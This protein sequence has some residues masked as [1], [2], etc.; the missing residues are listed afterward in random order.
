MST[1]LISETI[2]VRPPALRITTCVGVF[3]LL[4]LNALVRMSHKAGRRQTKRTRELV[5]QLSDAMTGIKPLMAMERQSRFMQLFGHKL[6]DLRRGLR[7]EVVSKQLMSNLREPILVV[8]LGI[9]FYITVK[10]WALPIS[11]LLVLGLLLERTANTIGKL[12]KQL[13]EVAAFEAAYWSVHNLI[14]ES[15]QEREQITGTIQPTLAKG[16]QVC[17]VSFGFGD[18][19][20][21]RNLSMD[22]HARQVTVIMGASGVG[23]TTLTDL[24]LGLHRP[25]EGQILIDGVPLERIDIRAWRAMVGYVPQE[26]IL[27]HD[28]ILANVTLGD[29]SIS[30]DAVQ[31]ALEA[32]GAWDFVSAMPDGCLSQVGERGMKL[33]GGERQRIAIARAL[34][35]KPDLLILDEVT[36]ALDRETELAICAQIRCLANSVTVVAITHRPAWVNIADRVYELGTDEFSEKPVVE[37]LM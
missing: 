21:L 14:N 2:W 37:Q 18:Q 5:T 22:I 19:P 15:A 36:S 28:S 33:S 7:R 34:V 12:Q 1:P 9:G 20:V 29:T 24:L 6:A 13:Q 35:N 16:C 25:D 30:E 27:F 10:Y 3:T 31:A 4:T 32:A 23:K 8:C 11:E 26:L 17:N